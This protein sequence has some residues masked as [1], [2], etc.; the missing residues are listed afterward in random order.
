MQQLDREHDKLNNLEALKVAIY[1]APWKA[2]FA[3]DDH[4]TIRRKSVKH[5]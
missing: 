1:N 4:A 3:D 2:Q 5:P